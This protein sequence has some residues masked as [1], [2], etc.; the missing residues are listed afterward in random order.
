MK[1]Y[2]VV[3]DGFQQVVSTD[4]VEQNTETGQTYFYRGERDEIIAVL[5]KEA[6]VVKTQDLTEYQKLL[7][8]AISELS[9][10]IHNDFERVH[11]K[12]MELED[13]K[14]DFQLLW[15]KRFEY[16]YEKTL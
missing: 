5:P 10:V 13:F 8:E 2:L 15:L 14:K 3:K 7:Q 11:P 12:L 1:N 4:L 9:D 16:L 6:I